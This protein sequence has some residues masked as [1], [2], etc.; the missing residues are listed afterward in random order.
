M[1]SQPSTVPTK[2]I[3]SISLAYKERREKMEEKMKLSL[4]LGEG[5]CTGQKVIRWYTRFEGVCML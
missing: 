2:S 4:G 1:A 5:G 3:R